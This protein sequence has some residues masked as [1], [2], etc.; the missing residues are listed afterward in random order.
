MLTPGGEDY[1]PPAEKEKTS[2]VVTF[3]NGWEDA[4]PSELKDDL[5]TADY[6]INKPLK[7]ATTNAVVDIAEM[8]AYKETLAEWKTIKALWDEYEIKRDEAQKNEED[9]P[10]PQRISS[11]GTC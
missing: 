8:E 10:P 9:T 1:K 4:D 7:P 3:Q 6:E 2:I 5:Y 11:S